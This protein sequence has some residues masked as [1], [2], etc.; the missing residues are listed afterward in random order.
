MP[1]K[2]WF[3]LFLRIFIDCILIAVSVVVTAFLTVSFFVKSSLR[4][5]KK[6][7]F[8]AFDFC[9]VY[10]VNSCNFV[11]LSFVEIPLI[12]RFNALLG[13]NSIFV[14]L[15]SLLKR[16]LTRLYENPAFFDAVFCSTGI[17]CTMFRLTRN[18]CFFQVRELR[19][20]R[21]VKSLFSSGFD[22]STVLLCTEVT[23]LLYSLSAILIS[24]WMVF[25]SVY[26]F[27]FLVMFP[28]SGPSMSFTGAF[29][30][31]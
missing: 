17:F 4:L 15:T 7:G 18:C 12:K 14:F 26:R 13:N 29:K 21:R 2:I 23:V 27:A 22:R 31:W 16:R 3:T 8:I 25:S 19:H 20:D 5:I 30:D 10:L 28:V 1:I 6:K 11:Y 24:F 9:W